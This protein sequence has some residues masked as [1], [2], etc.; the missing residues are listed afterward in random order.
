MELL[1]REMRE[2]PTI[3]CLA[4]FALGILMGRHLR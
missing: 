4:V 1:E 3:T 2:L